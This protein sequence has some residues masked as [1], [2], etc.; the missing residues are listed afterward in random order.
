MID[1]CPNSR[2]QAPVIE[3]SAFCVSCGAPLIPVPKELEN[4][5]DPKRY[6]EEFMRDREALDFPSDIAP[7]SVPASSRPKKAR[8]GDAEAAD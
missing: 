1:R 3:G 4:H 8:R 6:V 5:P 2:C 7:W